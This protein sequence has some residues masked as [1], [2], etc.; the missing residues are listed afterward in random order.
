MINLKNMYFLVEICKV[1]LVWY[2]RK[3]K[4]YYGER[5]VNLV[6]FVEI[7]VCMLF[8]VFRLYDD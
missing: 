6:V 8:V 5:I 4:F 3:N 1:L 7:K 2:D